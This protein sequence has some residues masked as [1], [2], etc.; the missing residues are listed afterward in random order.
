MIKRVSLIIVIL[1]SLVRSMSMAQSI[2]PV[3]ND[4]SRPPQPTLH[5]Y[6]KHGNPLPEPVMFLAELD[7]VSKASPKPVYPLLESLSFGVNFF[8]GV[9]MLAGQ[10]HASID[11]WGSLSLHNWVQPVV[12]LGVGWADDRPE[13]GNFHYIGK[14]SFYAKIG[15]DYNFLYKSDPAYQLHVGLRAG[16]SHFSYDIKDITISSSYWDQ[17]NSFDLTGQKAH[18]LF[19][20]FLA[21]LRVKIWRNFSMGWDVRFRFK[22]NVSDGKSS[23]PWFVPGYGTGSLISGSFSLIWTMPLASKKG[24]SPAASDSKVGDVK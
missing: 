22:M 24:M 13:E 17:T 19:G 5:Y 1:M 8:D 14:P 11:L 18:A 3:D 6:D 4:P 10:K 7:T 15:A 9:M 21:G 12:E 2:T 16:Y 23:T 20:E